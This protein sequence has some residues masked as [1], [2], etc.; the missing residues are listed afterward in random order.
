[1]CA[2][3][4]THLFLHWLEITTLATCKIRKP[5]CDFTYFCIGGTVKMKCC[6]A[7]PRTL[8]TF[9]ELH[10]QKK[11]CNTKMWTSKTIYHLECLSYFDLS[12]WEG[13]RNLHV[14]LRDVWNCLFCFSYSTEH[15]ISF[16]L[17]FL[18]PPLQRIKSYN[19]YTDKTLGPSK[20][21][22]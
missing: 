16:N 22:L 10:W 8:T 21:W 9:T 14:I 20:V 6:L 1:M 7:F 5:Y 3:T 11:R 18:S 13:F 4:D 19:L 12:C 2:H 15:I 17:F